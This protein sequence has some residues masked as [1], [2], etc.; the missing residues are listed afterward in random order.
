MLIFHT[1][2]SFTR[3][4]IPLPSKHPHSN[5][6]HS[7]HQQ[8]PILPTLTSPPW[9]PQQE[10]THLPGSV[11]MWHRKVNVES[12]GL[13]KMCR[14][15]YY[16]ED[17]TERQGHPHIHTN[18]QT[19]IHVRRQCVTLGSVLKPPWNLLRAAGAAGGGRQSRATC[20]TTRGYRCL[21][22][23]TNNL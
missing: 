9:T 5:P 6:R 8:M 23:Y 15:E 21:H 11:H 12:G 19:H 20:G 13:R 3:T 2:P 16:S 10:P 4:P 22:T 17:A 14:W 7:H 18:R 1:T